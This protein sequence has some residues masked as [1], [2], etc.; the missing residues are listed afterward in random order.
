M[1]CRHAHAA[2]VEVAFGIST[3]QL[4]QEYKTLQQGSD[5]VEEFASGL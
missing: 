2:A 5:T 4:E 1:L 3:Q